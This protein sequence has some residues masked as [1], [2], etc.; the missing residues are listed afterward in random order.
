MIPKTTERTWRTLCIHSPTFPCKSSY[1]PG[2][3]ACPA[4]LLRCLEQ[5]LSQERVDHIDGS[6][7]PYLTVT[8][9]H[10]VRGSIQN[11]RASQSDDIGRNDC[12]V[13]QLNSSALN[14]RSTLLVHRLNWKRA[15]IFPKL[16]TPVFFEL[17]R[18][19]PVPA[20]NAC[21][22]HRFDHQKR[23]YGMEVCAA[24]SRIA[25]VSMFS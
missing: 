17:R 10:I 19:N 1:H 2:D 15:H 7:H 6:S 9:H 23:L 4:T 22:F 12:D 24:E 21:H 14:E 3:P 13:S 16:L 18:R 25:L 11:V 8:G 5:T 20:R